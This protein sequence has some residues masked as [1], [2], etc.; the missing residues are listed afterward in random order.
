VTEEKI[1]YLVYMIET[2]VEKTGRNF[3]TRSR[4]ENH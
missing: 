3:Q 2:F 1:K 4:N